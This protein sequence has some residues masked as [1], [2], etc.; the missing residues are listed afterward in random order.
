MDRRARKRNNRSAGQLKDPFNSAY[1]GADE[2]EVLPERTSDSGTGNS[3][4]GNQNMGVWVLVANIAFYLL[5]L[6]LV[7]FILG[8]SWGIYARVHD[9]LEIRHTSEDDGGE[10]VRKMRTEHGGNIF[11]YKHD[12]YH[13]NAVCYDDPEGLCR[14]SWKGCEGCSYCVG[15]NCS[16][17]CEIASDCP[18][19]TFSEEALALLGL[20]ENQADLLEYNISCVANIC[21]Y[22]LSEDL[23][24]EATLQDLGDSGNVNY[25]D[26]LINQTDPVTKTGECLV[27]T[28]IR[29]ANGVFSNCQ[30]TYSCAND[31]NIP[32]Y[33]EVLALNSGSNNLRSFILTLFSKMLEVWSQV[34]IL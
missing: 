22:T 23:L 14:T 18:E 13:C 24:N 16:G 4:E 21:L 7:L 29:N 32:T 19:H 27:H 1:I 15:Q 2:D 20:S 5:L 28:P 6:A 26:R 25:C 3:M 9:N 30:H 12:K 8:L 17:T 31:P 10:C 34:M 11:I 33:D